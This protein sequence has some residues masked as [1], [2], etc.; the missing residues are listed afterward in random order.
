MCMTRFFLFIWS[1][2]SSLSDSPVRY[3]TIRTGSPRSESYSH[4]TDTDVPQGKFIKDIDN[5][6]NAVVCSS[7]PLEVRWPSLAP[8]SW[9]APT[10]I[11]LPKLVHSITVFGAATITARHRMKIPRGCRHRSTFTSNAGCATTATLSNTTI[12]YFL[13]GQVSPVSS[14][15]YVV[16]Y[17]I[18]H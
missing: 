12:Y 16:L 6:R 9:K 15:E 8:S 4:Y 13:H 11:P 14:E 7:H 3:H 1:P 18:G 5:E 2:S 17:F 10:N